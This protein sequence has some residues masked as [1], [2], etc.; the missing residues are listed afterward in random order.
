ME[1]TFSGDKKT[2]NNYI[3]FFDLDQTITKSISGRALAREAFRKGLMTKRDLLSAIF[4]SVAFRLRLRDPLRIIDK[5]VSWVRGIPEKTMVEICHNVFREA[6]LPFIYP[7]ARSEIDLHRTRNA[8]VVI[9]SSALNTICLEIAKSLN[10]DDVICSEL[11]VKNGYMTGLP[12]GHLCFAEEKA[13]RLKEYCEKNNFSLT[14]AWYYGDS[15]SDLPPLNAVG[16]PVCVNP[17]NQL[18]KTALKRNWKIL[19]WEL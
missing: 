3:V 19:N 5:M 2:T 8:K 10:L 14:D 12:V 17:D 11:E 18:R 16:N 15:V 6:L 9:L 13:I 4:L 1:T 7:A